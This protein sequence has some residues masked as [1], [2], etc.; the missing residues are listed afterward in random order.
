M[1]SNPSKLFL[2]LL[3]GLVIVAALF[4][5][6]SAVRS[7][8]ASLVETAADPNLIREIAGY[9]GWSK[10]NSEPQLMPDR[11]ATLCA[12]G[13][14]LQFDES[15]NPHHNK[16][17]TVYVNEVARA[18]MFGQKRPTFPE[19]SVIVKEKLANKTSQTPELMTVMIKRGKTYN[20]KNGNWE[21]IVVDGNGAK[22]L[23]RGKLEA[24]ESCHDIV[25]FNTDYVFRTYLSA[26]DTKKLQ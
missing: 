3:L 9:R 7:R 20:P 25:R 19:G 23:D 15:K 18:A 26:E 6:Y 5:G 8:S 12:P 14:T 17:L 16:Y 2:I 10:V 1:F 24:C 13:G 4:I 22:I 11:T 21:Y